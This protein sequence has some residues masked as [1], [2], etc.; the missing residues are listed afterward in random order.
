MVLLMVEESFTQ[1]GSSDVLMGKAAILLKARFEVNG[2]MFFI[3]IRKP[4]QNLFNRSA[5]ALRIKNLHG[6]PGD[7]YGC[8]NLNL[9]LEKAL[10]LPESELVSLDSISR[11]LAGL[12]GLV[13]NALGRH[14]LQL[15]E[16]R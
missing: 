8:V 1:L 10:R 12:M 7:E 16:I 11:R 4:V 6:A 2:I 9:I 5:V 14:G 3:R 13:E 15:F